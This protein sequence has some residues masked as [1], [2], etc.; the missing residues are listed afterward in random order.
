MVMKNYWR[1]PNMAKEY[2]IMIIPQEIKKELMYD[3]TIMLTYTIHYPH[4]VSNY[5]QASLMKLNLKYREKAELFRIYCETRLFKQAVEQYKYSLEN[6]YPFFPY[7][8]ILIYTVTYNENCA[9]SLY[10]D[11][12]EYT[13]GAHGITVRTSNTWNLQ[14]G[15][16]YTLKDFYA[17]EKGYKDYIISN[18]V[19]QIKVQ[20][21]KETG[22]YFDDYE[23][24]VK[25]NFNYNNF[26]ITEVGMV[27]YFQQYDIAPYSSGIVEF[28][29]PFKTG[30]MS[31]PK[32]SS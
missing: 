4:F 27:I 26:Y 13:G 20:I 10:F 2:N 31:A 14:C 24:L 30:E 25:E 29:I 16:E 32:C 19:N 23:N 17:G 12:Y 28:L 5:F 21:S 6:Q 18:I 15:T 3:K 8:C 7:E 22:F 9:I 1:G 11:Q